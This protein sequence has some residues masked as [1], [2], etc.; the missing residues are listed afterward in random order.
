MSY[1]LGKTI[2]LVFTIIL[3]VIAPA[4]GENWVDFARFCVNNWIFVDHDQNGIKPVQNPYI[5]LDLV[6]RN[7]WIDYCIRNINWNN[8]VQYYGDKLPTSYYPCGDCDDFAVMLASFIQKHYGIDTCVAIHRFSNNPNIKQGHAICL[9]KVPYVN[10][11]YD[12]ITEDGQHWTAIDMIQ[13][14][15]G[16]YTYSPNYWNTR[17]ETYEADQLVGTLI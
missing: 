7:Y 4:C 14:T 5:S 16:I 13:N 9:V 15:G 6:T 17:A 10:Y 1:K 2:S 11:G 3:A 8:W 12:H